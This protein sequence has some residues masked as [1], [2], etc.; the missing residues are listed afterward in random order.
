MAVLV[1]LGAATTPAFAHA[2]F[3]SS[4]PQPGSG[5]PQA[6]GEVV[7]RFS[8]PLVMD[9]SSVQVLDQG[10][11]AATDGP[12]RSVE[13]SSKDLR[14]DLG[15]LAPGI[16]TV[17][18]TTLSP[19]DGH[20]LTGSY[21][22]AIGATTL[23]E[24]DV[25]AS[26]LSSEGPLG[27]AGRF[28]ALAGLAVWIGGQLLA[29]PAGRAGLSAG[30]RR[31][32]TRAAA[33]AAAAGTILSLA[34]TALVATGS[35]AALPAVAAGGRSGLLRLLVA[36][37]AAAGAVL[38]GRPRR[39]TLPLAILAVL[40]EA[41]SGHAAS[42]P[43]P[44]LAT[45]ASAAH[46]AAVGVWVY[47]VLA[48]LAARQRL[49]EALSTFTPHAVA[50]GLLV[51]ATGTASAALQLTSVGDLVTTAYGQTVAM[52]ALPLVAMGA[53]GVVHYRRRSDPDV[54]TRRLRRPLAV[55]LLAAA[56][57][58]G[59][60]TALVGFP[61]PPQ[62]QAVSEVAADTQTQLQLATNGPAVTFA[63]ATGPYVLGVTATPPRPGKVTVLAQV[64]GAEAGDAIREVTVEATGPE[65]RQ[66]RRRLTGCGN[67]CWK[68]DIDLDAQGR[69]ELAVTAASN[70]G[71]L[72]AASTF[73]LPT[74]EG[75]R[76]FQQTL[77]AMN[78]I[79][80]AKVDEKLRDSL[81]HPPIV[82]DYTFVA[83]DRMRWTVPT[84]GST[85]I[86]VGDTGYLR[87]EDA[88]TWKRYP[89]TGDP[90]SWPTGFYASFFADATAFRVVER[91]RHNGR[92]ATVLTFVQPSYP[93]WY[94]LWT[95]RETNR[96]LRLE[97]RA[98]KHVMDQRYGP[99]NIPL[100]VTA[101]PA[102]RTVAR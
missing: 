22:F 17:K 35:L 100:E 47:A 79:R 86:A 36:A 68:A 93:A 75:T 29:G 5:L 16:Y 46:L 77:Q 95:D 56:A 1:G 54:Q 84:G 9:G 73:Q 33:S 28:V 99:Y 58:L 10:G 11:A 59:V 41:A 18:W 34:S 76:I 32:I 53:A 101:P 70:R 61:N 31:R 82:S 38:A 37:A 21:K 25:Q 13:N 12:T 63:R 65:G 49:R 15:L 96:V 74:P 72:T 4:Q 66:A 45:A 98:E 23:G 55:E 39:F 87:R 88:T 3:V 42:N 24:Q 44:Q 43:D 64:L 27:L 69:W 52:K 97:M 19:L 92:P 8:E 80:S 7:L 6:P 89:W 2:S 102:D 71:R 67:D 40:A 62:E 83:P 81:R 94:R 50:A 14:R 57:G 51:A 78:K 30:G 20:T 85:R 48:S 91:T 26:P 60:A 90:F